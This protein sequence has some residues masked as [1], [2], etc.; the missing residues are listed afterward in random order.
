MESLQVS[1]GTWGPTLIQHGT[2]EKKTHIHT[3]TYM[4]VHL[5]K[6]AN[7]Y[8]IRASLKLCEREGV[9]LEYRWLCQQDTPHSRSGC[10]AL[11]YSASR[12]GQKLSRAS[13]DRGKVL[14]EVTFHL[15][16][17]RYELRR[18]RNVAFQLQRELYNFA[19][20][21][22]SWWRVK[23]MQYTMAFRQAHTHTWHQCT[24]T[25]VA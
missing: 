12:R 19:G 14:G 10:R 2:S 21:E 22:H 9:L 8:F 16:E 17:L 13:Q 18:C 25:V 23:V 15:L 1:W 11:I 24:H 3:H 6:E 7:F 5:L 4:R 20:L